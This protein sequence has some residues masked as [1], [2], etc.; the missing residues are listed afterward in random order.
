ME[1][2]KLLYIL[3]AVSPAMLM[4]GIGIHA[5]IYVDPFEWPNLDQDQQRIKAYIPLAVETQDKLENRSLAY[6]SV[7]PA[8][9]TR[10]VDGFR[11]GALEP[12]MATTPEENPGAG[13]K[14][15]VMSINYRL[16]RI[17]IQSADEEIESGNY[18]QA[19]KVLALASDTLN[20][21]KYS[22]FLSLYR[23][24]LAQHSVLSRLETVYPKVP[25]ETQ[26]E[27]AKV[28]LRMQADE[29]RV[30]RLARHTM[31]LIRREMETYRETH[32][33]EDGSENT[34]D[35][36]LPFEHPALAKGNR[37]DSEMDL[38]M[39][40]FA[41]PNF[42]LEVRQCVSA[43]QRNRLLIEKITSLSSHSVS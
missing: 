37:I 31:F 38:A 10:W 7:A 8:L 16:A 41:L 25:Y 26:K 33:T 35:L 6:Q 17:L 2:R 4:G 34:V 23:I 36:R 1:A 22:N 42:S 43:D 19:S 13:T 20:C 5:R 11:S 15:K 24:T 3:L 32:S 29:G 30:R 12:L 40:E 9:A 18:G 28:M 39:L 21:F 27:L 14:G